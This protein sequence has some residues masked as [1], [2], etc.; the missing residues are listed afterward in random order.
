M[1]RPARAIT[2]IITIAGRG[3]IGPDTA[4]RVHRA[5]PDHGGADIAG[6]TVGAIMATAGATAAAN[7]AMATKTAGDP[8]ESRES[9]GGASSRRD[10]TGRIQ[11]EPATGCLPFQVCVID[12]G[13]IA[14]P[15]VTPPPK[16]G[17]G[18]GSRRLKKVVENRSPSRRREG[19][20]TAIRVNLLERFSR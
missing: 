3:M 1:D 9:P 16:A 4:G 12:S 19:S 17:A 18:A 6:V 5:R 2:T 8:V 11:A 7:G 14:P 20:E 10:N 15:L 13:P